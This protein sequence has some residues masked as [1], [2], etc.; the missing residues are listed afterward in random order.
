VS[1]PRID[2]HLHSN[3]SDGSESPAVVMRAAKEAG[4]DIVALTDHDTTDGWDEAR[5]AC[6]DLGIT[7]VPGIEFSASSNGHIVHLLGYLVDPAEPRFAET[8]ER[9]RNDR[10][11][12]FEKM[13]NNLHQDFGGM[14]LEFAYSFHADG[15]TLGRPTIARAL[16]DLGI[17]STVSEAF[18]DL[19]SSSNK[20]YYAGHSA[21]TIEDAIEL[22]RGA[23]G[24]PVLAHPWTSTRTTLVGENDTD[25]QVEA[26]FAELVALGLAG[27]EVHHE[28]NTPHGRE[29]LAAIAAHLG[30]IVTGS[31][32]YHGLDTKPV[33]PGANTT[34]LMN[35]E[36]IVAL[37]TGSAIS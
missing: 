34:S 15:A 13:V 37:G 21:P 36:R 11:W 10:Q 2:L 20:R 24:V 16:I 9:T 17:V 12:R 33:K 26:Q 28:E 27:L 29:R 35:F 32:D 25:E 6:A 14:T 31:S 22:V 3:R 30:L 18:D 23:G 8:C 7:F 4:L 1:D 19:L 5:A